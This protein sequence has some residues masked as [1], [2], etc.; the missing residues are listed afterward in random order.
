MHPHSLHILDYFYFASCNNRDNGLLA[1]AFL[2]H[3]P[4]GTPWHTM[5]RLAGYATFIPQVQMLT[6]RH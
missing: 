3:G 4:H 6:E 1:R 2:D 5:A